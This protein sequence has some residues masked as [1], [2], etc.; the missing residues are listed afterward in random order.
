M[1]TNWR[2]FLYD[3]I[4][5]TF[6]VIGIFILP[7]PIPL[8][9]IFFAFGVVILAV[10]NKSARDLV[11]A[12]RRQSHPLNRSIIQSRKY[13]PPFI[14]SVIDATNPNTKK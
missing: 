8:G 4:G 14:Q 5:I 6:I 1:K 10:E 3:I 7:L 9:I 12:L 11:C 2:I 13:M